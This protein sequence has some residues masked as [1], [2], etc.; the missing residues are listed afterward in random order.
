MIGNVKKLSLVWQID[1]CPPRKLD[2]GW[3]GYRN[4]F[5]LAGGSVDRIIR[6]KPSVRHPYFDDDHVVWIPYR[7]DKEVVSGVEPIVYTRE[8][9][10]LKYFK[11]VDIREWC[12]INN[13]VL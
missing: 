4:T 13:T 1:C 2:W 7:T 9:R 6:W 12:P 3:G 10:T 5:T 11:D 8:K